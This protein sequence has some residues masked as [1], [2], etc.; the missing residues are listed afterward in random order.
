VALP[1]GETRP[2]WND[3]RQVLAERGNG[4][5]AFDGFEGDPGSE[6]A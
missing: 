4:E 2:P 3:R 1:A 6:L 5:R